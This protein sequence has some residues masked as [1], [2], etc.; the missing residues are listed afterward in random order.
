MKTIVAAMDENFTIGDDGKLLWNIP[1][2]MSRFR[3]LTM[4]KNVVMGMKTWLSLPDKFRPLPGRINWVL[5]RQKVEI[6]GAHV[7][8]SVDEI[9]E[10]CVIIGGGEIYRQTIGMVDRMEITHVDGH[11]VGDA[12]FPMFDGD[13]WVVVHRDLR[14]GYSFVTYDRKCTSSAV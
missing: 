10:M 4:G 1:E 5:T 7:I 8:H 12:K 6:V 11:R 2:D 13:D 3:M 14:D 9:P